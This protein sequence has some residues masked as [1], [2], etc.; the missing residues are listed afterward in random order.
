MRVTV[1]ILA[2]AA[3]LC[4]VS[5]VVSTS[6]GEDARRAAQQMMAFGPPEAKGEAWAAQVSFGVPD[7]ARY[8]PGAC[9]WSSIFG[10]H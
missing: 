6:W 5:S 10:A 1:K 2:G 8:C 3:A 4:L 7:A 9:S